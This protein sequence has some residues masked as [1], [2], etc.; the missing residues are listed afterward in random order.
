M[1]AVNKVPAALPRV[2]L[3]K[4]LCYSDVISPPLGL[5]YLAAALAGVAEV[6]I[7]DDLKNRL[8]PSRLPA[9][10]KKF[11]PDLVGLSVV[12]A[13]VHVSLE[14]ISV[15]RQILPTA[16]ILAGGPHPS[17]MPEQYYAAAR[18][19]LDYIL[20]GDAERSLKL[21]LERCRQVPG[22]DLGYNDL[23]DIPGI[24]AENRNNIIKT[25]MP[26]NQPCDFPEMPVWA[27]MPPAGYPKAPQGAFF[28]EFPVAP[29]ITTR[30]CPFECGFCSVA[31][32]KGR[33]VRFRNPE[34]I[35]EEISLLKNR[36]NVREIQFID[37]NFTVSKPHVLAVCEKMVTDNLV[38]PWTCPNGV[39][40][41]ML[42]EEILDAMKAAGCY[43]ISVGIESGTQ[44]GLR[45]MNKDLDLD[46][47]V[48][49]V[50]TI[51]KKNI[52]VNGFFVLGYPGETKE[53]I[54]ETIQLAKALPLTRAHFML[55]TPFPGCLGT[56]QVNHETSGTPLYETTFAQ[57]SYVP[58]GFTRRSVKWWHRRAMISFYS[59][60][61]KVRMLL[62][63][64]N[65][66]AMMKYFFR[67]VWHWLVL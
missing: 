20:R 58:E 67:R 17:L 7:V 66:L 56:D 9:L 13:A 5:G 4:P 30:G 60:P 3:L 39:R 38:L 28:R 54:K 37:D 44:A 63:D 52:G 45:R 23:K 6:L 57:V 46:K 19:K 34:I 42:D 62:R 24:Y 55:F 47:A 53:N 16:I 40:A 15:I 35:T 22:A 8:G 51:A 41:D 43:S 29:L 64:I 18:G 36:Y 49:A 21:L 33:A 50:N 32:L 1:D 65:S 61:A 14:Y 31:N 48:T 2:M 26:L 27:L 12:S 25:A 59:Q 10:L 11:Q